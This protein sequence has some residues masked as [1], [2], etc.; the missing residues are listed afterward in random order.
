MLSRPILAL[1]A[2]SFGIGTTEFVIMG[3][4]PEVADS[5]GVSVPRAGLLVSGYALG[6]AVGAPIVA[7]ATARLPRKAALLVLMAV[8]LL[9]NLG[10]ALA[11]SYDLLMLARI[12]TAFAHGAFF[13]IGAVV[14]ASLVPR[15]QRTQAVALMFAGLTLANVLGVPFGTALGQFAGWR[16]T[17]WAV[18]AL[19]IVAAAA[20][21]AYVPGGMPGSRGGLAGE[22]RSLRR[23]PVL[24]PMLVSTLASVSLFTV[25]TY[26]TPLLEDVSG[27]TP[28]QVTGAL[29]LFGV[30]L[31][32]GNL[33]G[34]RLADRRL[35]ATVIGAFS[36]LVVVLALFAFT[37]KAAI[38]AVLTLPVW[39]ALVFALVAP[40]QVWVVEAA[41]DAPNLASTLNQGAFNLGNA[42]GAALGGAVVTAGL[43]YGSLPWFGAAIALLALG[44]TLTAR[45]P[46]GRPR[47]A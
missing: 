45:R 44:L 38:P 34:G 26:I 10:C 5:F 43:G 40:L 30:G 35:M 14:A 41:T 19:G 36:A 33:A 1:A 27:L 2:A 29:L 15:E 4:L 3:L 23:W 18:L 20:I 25:F 42:T 31:T 11:P 28:T 32:L 39:G 6:V 13:G 21:L 22:F 9:G 7:I 12:V 16:A 47:I 8:F 46:A 37:A 17:F 24:L